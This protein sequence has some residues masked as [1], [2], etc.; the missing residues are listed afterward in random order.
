MYKPYW[1]VESTLAVIGTGG[2]SLPWSSLHGWLSARGVQRRIPRQFVINSEGGM[3]VTVCHVFMQVYTCM[4]A[5]KDTVQLDSYHSTCKR[6]RGLRKRSL[7]IVWYLQLV[8][9]GLLLEEG[10]WDVR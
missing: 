3:N 10:D 8:G 6:V 7:I 5:H 2:P 9:Q 4:H 1:G